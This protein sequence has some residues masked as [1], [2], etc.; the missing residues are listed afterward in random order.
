MR[1][2]I[3]ARVGQGALV[4]PVPLLRRVH[5]PALLVRGEKDGM[6]PFRNAADHAA[7]LPESEVVSFPEP[8]HVPQEEAPARSLEPV[9]A[10]LAR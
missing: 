8:G 7:P 2:A 10:F 4:D 3:L 6:V 9:R 1:R 5:A